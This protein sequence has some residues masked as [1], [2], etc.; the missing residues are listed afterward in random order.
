MSKLRH[1]SRVVAFQSLVALTVNGKQEAEKIFNY[2]QDEFSPELR[3]SDF[4]RKIFFGVIANRDFLD[5]EIQGLAP[6]WPISKLCSIERCVLEMGCYELF[7]VKDTPL[8]VVIDECVEIAKEFGD[9][10]AGK[11]VNGVLSSFAKKYR[12]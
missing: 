11:F 2:V 4:A 5:K 3:D 6:K 9:E 8:A 12:N 7:D 10:T 1:L